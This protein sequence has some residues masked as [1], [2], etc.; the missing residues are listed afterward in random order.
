MWGQVRFCELSADGVTEEYVEVNHLWDKSHQCKFKNTKPRDKHEA[1]PRIYA[2]PNDDLCPYRFMKFY[3]GLCMKTQE[4]VLCFGATDKQLKKWKKTN[5]PYLYNPNT[6]VGENTVGPLCKEMAEEMGFEEYEKCTGHGLRKMGISHAMTN[7]P[8]SATPVVLKASR[9]KRYQTSLLYQ[10]PNDDMYRNYSAAILGKHVP[11]PPRP[12][13]RKRRRKA[14]NAAAKTSNE[15]DDE[16]NDHE[17]VGAVNNDEESG[18]HTKP[19]GVES[20][21][22]L[23]GNTYCVISPHNSSLSREDA[24]MNNSVRTGVS[25]VCNDLK[26]DDTTL[27]NM[28]YRNMCAQHKVTPAITPH[29]PCVPVIEAMVDRSVTSGRLSSI[30]GLADDESSGTSRLGRVMVPY[31]KGNHQDNYRTPHYSMTTNPIYNTLQRNIIVAPSSSN[32]NDLE[33]ERY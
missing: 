22:T 26:V 11:T 7:A 30:S 16:T 13:S 5:Q 15:S 23:L 14:A 4:R 25:S 18:L 27:E 31:Q 28:S 8:T 3:R 6:P 17:F 32:D 24:N 2:N 20:G 10:R 9:H 29:V 21:T 19:A 1:C 33:V 12:A